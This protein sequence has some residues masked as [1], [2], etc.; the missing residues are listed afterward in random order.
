MNLSKLFSKLNS[1]QLT[2]SSTKLLAMIITDTFDGLFDR[3]ISEHIPPHIAFLIAAFQSYNSSIQ[4]DNTPN[5]PLT[6]HPFQS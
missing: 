2:N 6:L 1:T 3:G 5:T 4:T